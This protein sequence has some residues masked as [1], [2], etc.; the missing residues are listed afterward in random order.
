MIELQ[1]DARPGCNYRL[2]RS[3]DLVNWAPVSEHLAA[4][5]LDDASVRLPLEVR[6]SYFRV[7]PLD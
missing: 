5:H 7:V 1:W 2:E 6:A 4:D 3:D